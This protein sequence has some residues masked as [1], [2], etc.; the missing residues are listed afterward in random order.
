[1]DRALFV[2]RFQPFHNGHLAAVRKLLAMHDEVIIVIGSAEE[3]ISSINPFTAGE[4]MDMVRACF[5][6]Q[7]LGRLIMVPLRDINN[8]SLW[9]SHVSSHVPKFSTVYSNNWLVKHLFS[10]EGY[11]MARLDF[12]DRIHCEGKK[13]RAMIAAGKKGWEK[14]VPKPVVMYLRSID[15]IERMKKIYNF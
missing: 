2:G 5:N 11:K 3:S 9:V 12:F 6:K 1:M 7:E 13:I 8:N 14:Y 15:G 10:K 4:R